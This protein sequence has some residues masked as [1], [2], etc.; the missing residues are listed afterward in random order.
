[1]LEKPRKLFGRGSEDA[2]TD[3]EGVEENVYAAALR[4]TAPLLP[5][6][7]IAVTITM[8]LVS[9][10]ISKTIGVSLGD[11]SGEIAVLVGILAGVLVWLTVAGFYRL[12]TAADCAS[13]RNYNGLRERLNYLDIRIRQAE[14]DDSQEEHE[15]HVIKAMRDQALAR[16]KTECG[17]IKKGLASKGMPWVTGLGYIELWHRVH[18]AEEAMI[19]VEPI[20]EALEGAMRDES[21]LMNAN[22]ENKEALLQRLRNAVALLDTSGT[23][24]KL[25]LLA[26]P[27]QISM[28]DDQATPD[29]SARALTK[30]NRELLLQ[31]LRG[32]L[33]RLVNAVAKRTNSATDRNLSLLAEPALSSAEDERLTP[34]KRAKALI[35][36]SEVRYEINNFRDNSWEGLVHARTRLADTS[37]LLGVV[38]YGLLAL[39]LFFEASRP[40]IIWVVTYFLIGALAGLFARAQAEWSAES[41]VDDFGLSRSRL[42]Q[43]PWLSGLAAVGGVL[44]TSILDPQLTVENPTDFAQITAVFSS[45]PLLLIVAAIFGLTPDLLLRRLAQQSDKYKEDLQSTQ[46]SQSTEVSQSSQN[47]E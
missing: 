36:L 31:R 18:H 9:R 4:V 10:E 30:E 26:E 28:E 42:L 20:P 47:G 11:L 12:H 33:A 39:A 7:A 19:K 6:V 17:E 24:K 22:M 27:A 25:N 32:A 5:S 2:K 16:A 37:V 38:A 1:M 3:N 8:Y 41:A 15:Q 23:D 29:K 40:T 34:D 43:I 14:S 45:R 46:S 35:M 21:R 13:R 44:I